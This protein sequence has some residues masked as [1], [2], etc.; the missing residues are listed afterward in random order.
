MIPNEPVAVVAVVGVVVSVLTV[1]TVDVVNGVLVAVIA[2]ETIGIVPDGHTSPNG[3]EVTVLS[4]RHKDTIIILKQP[5][6]RARC[7]VGSQLF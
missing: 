4:A 5:Y 2:V 6:P 7:D 3:V 1:L